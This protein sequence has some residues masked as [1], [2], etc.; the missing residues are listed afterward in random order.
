MEIFIVD[1]SP[2]IRARLIELLGKV[3]GAHVSGTA[4]H[5]EEAIDAI[6]ATTPDLVVLDLSLGTQSG[7]EV[8]RAIHSRAPQIDVY[9]L[10]NFSTQPYRQY[11]TLL[12]ARGFFD[13]TNEFERVRDV[14][15]QR[16]AVVH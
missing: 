11:A 5:V 7:F 1:D 14:V 12:G 13:K 15:A 9:M 6:L 4:A 3:P 16:A 2:I 8:L 10:S